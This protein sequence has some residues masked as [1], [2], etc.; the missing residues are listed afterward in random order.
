[1]I[2]P[3]LHYGSKANLSFSYNNVLRMITFLVLAC[4][5][6][7]SEEA[8]Y[9]QTAPVISPEM[10]TIND[11]LTQ[12][13]TTIPVTKVDDVIYFQASILASYLEAEVNESLLSLRY[14]L[15]FAEHVIVYQVGKKYF[16][17]DENLVRLSGPV[18]FTAGSIYLPLEVLI[19][20]LQSVLD[21]KMEWN[22]P[23]LTAT[24]SAQQRK[25]P[26][27]VKEYDHQEAPVLPTALP[28][29]GR[30]LR[31]ITIDPGH[32]GKDSGAIG[33]DGLLEKDVVLQISFLLKEQ[34]QKK[35]GI[36]AFLTREGDTFYSLQE[37]TSI[38]NNN[39]SDIFL[40]IHMNSGRGKKTQGFEV[41][42][43]NRQPSDEQAMETATLENYGVNVK[44]RSNDTAGDDVNSILWDLIQNKYLE[45][46]SILAEKI[47]NAHELAFER[48]SRGVKQAPFYILVG[49]EMP[50][51]LIEVDFIS[52]PTQ[53]KQ[54]MNDEY[55]TKIVTALAQGIIDF[56]KHYE[57]ILGNS[58]VSNY[59]EE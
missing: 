53:E 59:N 9:C 10:I 6:Y 5:V 14:E 2:Q 52:N 33:P 32:G 41:Y 44:A 26:S 54:M 13:T 50:A 1:M 51:V 25:S 45:E 3:S 12:Q 43:L 22:A 56:K 57:K 8:V 24:I 35:Y 27:I 7:G 55:L 58:N 23:Q 16:F 15:T 37:R 40:S 11:A 30:K 31:S 29:P 48:L 49:A 47:L 39:H 19:H 36:D 18:T 34:L 21:R 4:L 20:T 17:I 28:S 46:S 38:A 42:Y